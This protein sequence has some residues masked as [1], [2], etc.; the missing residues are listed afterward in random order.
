MNKKISFG[1]IVSIVILLFFCFICII[2]IIAIISISLSDEMDIVKNG[3]SLIPKKISFEA[4]AYMFKGS[5]QILR[6]Y[7]VSITL[8]VAGTLSALV[9]DT[10]IAYPLSRSDFKWRRPLMFYVFFTMIF[11]GGLIPTYMVVTRVLHI[12]NTML[13]LMVPHLAN[14]WY[15]ILLRTFFAKIPVSLI[16]SARLDGANEVRTLWSI[17][18][19]LA[20]PALA[21][22][23]LFLVLTFWNDWYQALLYT[24]PSSHL[25]PLQYQLYKIMSNIQF[26]T[27]QV[28]SAV[29][30]DMTKFPNESARM[31]M[32]IIA[33]GPMLFVFP[34]FQKYFVRGLTVGAVKG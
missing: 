6:S 1:K 4:Y 31:A 14:A 16:E 2:P 22:V 25:V 33:A 12:Q 20:K 3:Y 26:L 24:S 28:A 13:A 15:I 8:T 10:F 21:T 7:V 19:P 9:I 32:C 5:A 23:G 27:S 30:I 18:I 29:T 34:F 17:V 11:N